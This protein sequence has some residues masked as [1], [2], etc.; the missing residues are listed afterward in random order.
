MNVRPLAVLKTGLMTAVGSDA[1]TC[2]A[3]FRSKLNNPSPTRFMDSTG[4]W[5]MAHQVAL[6]GAKPGLSKHAR[7]AAT[8]VDEALSETPRAEWATI[9][10]LLCVAERERVGRLEGLDDRLLDMIQELLD[11]RFATA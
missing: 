2:C 8:V 10:L 4:E 5:I 6:K 9:P 3:S 11:V 7:M 1:P